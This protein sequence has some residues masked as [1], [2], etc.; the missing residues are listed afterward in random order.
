MCYNVG[1]CGGDT[2]ACGDR[3]NMSEASQV[4][5]FGE[6][7]HSIDEKNRLCINSNLR[8]GVPPEEEFVIMPGYDGCLMLM[9]VTDFLRRSASIDD[10]Q[11]G[12]D[13]EARAAIRDVFRR[14]VRVKLDSQ[15][16]IIIPQR[17][18]ED[19]EIQ[20]VC[21]ENGARDR[22]EIWAKERYEEY[23]RQNAGAAEKG[24]KAVPF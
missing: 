14:A 11:Y 22:I 13:A 4:V 18:K 10:D 7:E 8:A 23:W 24:G 6:F 12:S 20:K 2:L 3:P 19:A 1:R 9:T 17:L 21:V 5:F 15:G 16:R